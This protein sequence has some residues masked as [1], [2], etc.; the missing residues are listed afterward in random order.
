MVLEAR[1]N[2]EKVWYP[3]VWETEKDASNVVDYNIHEEITKDASSVI[4]ANNDTTTGMATVIP[5][6]NAPK[7]IA[8]TSIIWDLS[9]EEPVQVRS[10]I[11]AIINYRS[12]GSQE[13]LLT[14]ISITN[15]WWAWF[16]V[17]SGIITVGKA[18]IYNIIMN[19]P[20]VWYDWS[21]GKSIRMYVN[22]AEI[23]KS[24]T[25]MDTTDVVN[26]TMWLWAWDLIKFTCTISDG[27]VFYPS[28]TLTILFTKQ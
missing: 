18:W 22:N 28:W 1:E 15:E 24:I 20:N 6:I 13:E 8:S 9:W 16:T 27:G 17:S 26:Y 23:I 12:Y 4:N 14:N 2:A 7:L 19:I 11:S 25:V 3:I 21:Y 10:N 5:W